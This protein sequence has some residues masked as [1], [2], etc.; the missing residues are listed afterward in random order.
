MPRD[1]QQTQIARS[2]HA[3]YRSHLTY[4]FH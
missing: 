1:T 3:P 4:L 2:P